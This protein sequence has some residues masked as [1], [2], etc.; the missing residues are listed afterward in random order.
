MRYWQIWRL[1]AVLVEAPDADSGTGVR[2]K[3]PASEV[4]G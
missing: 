4:I 1:M 3:G 2:R